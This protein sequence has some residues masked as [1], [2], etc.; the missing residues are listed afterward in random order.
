[1]QILHTEYYRASLSARTHNFRMSMSESMNSFNG[2]STTTAD[3]RGDAR[4]VYDAPVRRGSMGMACVCVRACVCLCA[5]V[6][7]CVCA[8]ARAEGRV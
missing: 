7:V 4:G 5:C 3:G 8:R 6:C 1:M 2:Y